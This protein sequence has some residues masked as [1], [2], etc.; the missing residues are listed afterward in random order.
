[1]G[2]IVMDKAVL[3]KG[4]FIAAGAAVLPGTVIESG[5]LYAG[6]PA[7]K[8]KSLDKKLKDVIKKT[9]DNYIKYASWFD[10]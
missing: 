8:I 3:G 4:S 7:K 5:F 1:M 2:A 9:P 10:D 6:T